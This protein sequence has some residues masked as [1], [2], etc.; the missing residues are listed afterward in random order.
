MMVL[1]FL[2]Y[3]LVRWF[4]VSDR[5]KV[6]TVSYTDQTSYVISI[7]LGLWIMTISFTFQYYTYHSFE[8]K[9][10]NYIFIILIL[11]IYLA[12]RYIYIVKKRY[13]YISKY[14]NYGEKISTK[15]GMVI[16]LMFFCS[17]ILSLLTM[18][19]ILHSL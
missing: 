3:Y 1:D 2:F 11:L 10:P 13:D 12:I 5:R 19:I 15:A 18:A 17:G 14:K 9:I 7:C 4:E 16:S 8:S 6:K